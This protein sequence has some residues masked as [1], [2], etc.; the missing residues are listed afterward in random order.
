M[1]HSWLRSFHYTAKL[2]QI[3]AAA[4]HLNVSKSSI[5]YQIKQLEDYFNIRLFIRNHNRLALTEI[6][7]ELLKATTNYF[8]HE[9]AIR[10]ILSQTY[11]DQT[12]KIRIGSEH[13]SFTA[14]VINKILEETS[15]PNGFALF[16]GT[17]D[18]L[19]NWFLEHRI[20]III[21]YTPPEQV[22][23]LGE[24]TT[25]LRKDKAEFVAGKRYAERLNRIPQKDR[26][27]ALLREATWVIQGKGATARRVFDEL[28]DRLAESPDAIIEVPAYADVVDAVKENLGIGILIKNHRS[29]RYYGQPMRELVRVDANLPTDIESVLCLNKY[30]HCRKHVANL[31]EVKRFVDHCIELNP[32]TNNT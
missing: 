14:G 17:Q 2:G 15:T 10:R 29:G 19:E 11:A 5:S 27:Q 4:D 23:Q 13:P 32:P 30:I 21:S 18:V 7:E 8:E 20:D 26:L 24:Q 6:G 9:N 25:I 12:P 31:H 16:G 28:C 3:S 22:E 1:Q